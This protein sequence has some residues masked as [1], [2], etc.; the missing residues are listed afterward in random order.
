MILDCGVLH[1]NFGCVVHHYP[2]LPHHEG[3]DQILCH[4]GDVKGITDD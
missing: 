2:C 4:G 1:L 3:G